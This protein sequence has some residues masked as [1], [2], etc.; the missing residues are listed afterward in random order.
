MFLTPSRFATP[1]TFSTLL[2]L[3]TAIVYPLWKRRGYRPPPH[4]FTVLI[5]VYHSLSIRAYMGAIQ[6]SMAIGV[7]AAL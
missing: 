7:G 6:L 4:C 1:P 5:P 2:Y 3:G